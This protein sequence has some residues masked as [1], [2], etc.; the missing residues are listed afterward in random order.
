MPSQPQS[1]LGNM[2]GG[3]QKKKKKKP[4]TC[5]MAFSHMALGMAMASP[6]VRTGTEG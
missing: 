5:H 6:G 2:P 3:K 1:I 4:E